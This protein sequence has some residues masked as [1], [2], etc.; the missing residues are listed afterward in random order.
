M[1]IKKSAQFL[2]SATIFICMFA[3]LLSCG[4][5]GGDSD[6]GSS[7]GQSGSI[8]VAA[9]KT[10]LPAD[11][12]SSATITATIKDSAGNPVRHYT[13]VVF[14]TNLGTFRNGGK[15]YTVQTQPP[16]GADGLPN[17]D[18][19]PTGIAEA[20]L[21]AATQAGTAR[22]TVTS[23]GVTQAIN[24]ELT[25]GLVSGI[26]LST[27]QGSVS[28]DN[29][30]ST[31]ITATVLDSNN[32]A[33]KDTTISFKAS[34]GTLNAPSVVT[35]ENGQATVIFSCGN[36]DNSNR[37]ST[38]TAT[39]GS[40]SSQ[41]SILI[42][43]TTLDLETD[44]QNLEISASAI[45]SQIDN[46]KAILTIAVKDAGDNRI[47]N[48]L[49]TASVDPSST[50][51]VLLVPG[52]GYTDSTGEL[53][54]EVFGKAKGR[55]IV[56]VEGLGTSATQTYSVGLAGEVFSIISPT[57]DPYS[58]QKGASVT[59]VVQAPTQNQV[60]FATTCGAWD[61][62]TSTVVTKT[63]ANQQVSA[64]LSSTE[65][66]N[67]TV[68][69]YDA[70]D[71]NT[72]DSM[73]VNIYPPA[74]SA[75]RIDLQANSYVVARSTGGILNSVMLEATVRDDTFQIVPNVAVSFS[76]SDST[77]GGE[78]VSP[79]LAYTQP[80]SGKAEATFTSGSVSSGARGVTVTATVVGKTTVTDSTSI[81]IGGTAG[82][83][84]IGQ[85][86]TVESI[87]NDTTYKLPM[88]AQVVDSNGNPVAGARISLQLWPSYYRTGI[89][90]PTQTGPSN[91]VPE[92]SNTY[93]N[94]D[95]KFPGT[96]FYRNLILDPGE[97][98][99]GDGQLTPASSAAGSVPGEVVADET[100]VANF[101]LIYPKS[102]AV[103]IVAELTGSTLVLGS[104]TRST[105]EFG[106]PF[107]RA[108]AQVC[109]LPSSPYNNSQPTLEI[110]V[111]ATPDE[112]YPDGGISTSAIRAQV[113]QLGTPVADGTLV[114]FAITS[115][116]GGLGSA[117][118]SESS[119]ATTAGQASVIYFS[120]DRPGDVTIRAVLADG[121]SATVN[122]KLTRG[123]GEPFTIG[124][125]FLPEELSADGGKSQSY[126]RANVKDSD[127]FPVFDGTLITFAILSGSG[128]FT[129]PFPTGSNE[130]TDTTI[131][132][133]AST[134]YYSGSITTATEKVMI[135]AQ[136]DNGSF[137][138]KEL[139]LVEVIGSMTLTA[140][141]DSIPADG[142]SSSAITATILDNTGQPVAK[143]TAVTFVT[144][145][146]TILTPSVTTPD[147][148][149][150]V[151]V[152]LIA[153]TTAGTAIVTA[154]AT[155]GTSTLTQSVMVTIGGKTGTIVLTA[156]PSTIPPDGTSSSAITA[157]VRDNAGNPVEEGTEVTFTTSLTGTSF[158]NGTQ[159]ITV[160][161]E[162]AAGTATVSLI[163]GT[164]IG[165]SKI[166]A[167][168]TIG[169][170][171][172]TQTIYVNVDVTY[173]ITLWANTTSVVCGTST[174]TITA[175][176]EDQTGT[177]VS[178]V[179]I[180]FSTNNGGVAPASAG[181]TD[182]SGQTTTVFTPPG[183]PCTNGTAIVTGAY[184][185]ASNTISITYTTP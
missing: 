16:L 105:T 48:A 140:S 182:A 38:I 20:A 109:S 151:T 27:S 173:S 183:A 72:S 161:I 41:I 119:A 108:D 177:A 75:A 39:A 175:T 80:N 17:P 73:K 117:A 92:I 126:I 23:N 57:E 59:I 144:N 136:A 95:D 29:S 46:E 152:S 104:E 88:T 44:F 10:T 131:A 32:A 4:G 53:K 5:G 24:I 96:Y 106:L 21:I 172:V 18:A 56:K 113:T 122:L 55:V 134:V 62:G 30:D 81:V 103:W 70:A 58:L 31:T 42:T 9:D 110:A 66:C 99:N 50:G 129:A 148:S 77:G 147:D 33:L 76:I 145:L 83:V 149:G 98:A 116:I 165:T 51:D 185:D 37:T 22:V 89:W 150:V 159:T 155:S 12:S 184:Q 174:A 86:T 115:G 141:P 154:S 47:S 94:E 93:P 100:G 7:S 121:T 26:S 179:N 3:L 101:D 82:S 176:L 6:S 60:I 78:F 135:R 123:A 8:T 63:V 84:V 128:A 130:T 14:T 107:L 65:A 167:T 120:G 35:D 112:V 61:G 143:G 11:G 43:G 52:S 40:A 36:L 170:E 111:T 164:T 180:N 133:I 138:E 171:T 162:N 181:P 125:T 1:N 2:M 13:E 127:D 90:V 137:T 156:N 64:V 87:N 178:G 158:R 163:A 91:C 54:I 146:G 168:V 124:L 67:A 45:S 85:S 28:T 69:V 118:S 25:G 71:P 15:S 19:P 34:S 97:D 114:S 79:P 160:P 153:G 49:I 166:T 102:H 74:D 139:T 142:T 68:Q 169:A 132:G 157:T